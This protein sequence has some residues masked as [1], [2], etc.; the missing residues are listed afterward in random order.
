MKVEE[1]SLSAIKPNA[2]NPR[3]NDEAVNGV[4]ESIKTRRR[5][6]R[7]RFRDLPCGIDFSCRVLL[8]RE[9]FSASAIIFFQ[10][11]FL[12]GSLGSDRVSH[13]VLSIFW[14]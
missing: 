10:R 7:L 8:H 12:P 14:A 1:L 13:S 6:N 11:A 9:F 5:L 4:A 3:K 2:K